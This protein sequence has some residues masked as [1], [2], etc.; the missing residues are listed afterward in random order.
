[1]GKTRFGVA[2]RLAAG[3]IALAVFTMTAGGTALYAFQRLHDGFDVVAN[4]MLGDL[5]V[6]TRLVRESEAIIASAPALVAVDT[7]FLRHTVSAR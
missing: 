5:I 4:V 6:A 3:L 2:F 7:Q 1:M